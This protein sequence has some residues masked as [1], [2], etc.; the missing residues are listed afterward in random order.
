M[1]LKKE[2]KNKNINIYK[3]TLKMAYINW[4]SLQE[5]ITAYNTK[6]AVEQYHKHVNAALYH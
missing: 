5:N 6:V 1:N 4:K 3:Y 2:T